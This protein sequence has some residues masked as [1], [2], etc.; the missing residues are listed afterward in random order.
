M[1][2]Y[3]VACFREQGVDVVVVVVDVSV[4]RMKSSDQSAAWAR[5]QVSAIE[6]G[7][8]GT[9]VLLWRATSR[10]L[11]YFDPH[12]R[13]PLLK[14]L[15]PA[16]LARMTN[17]RLTCG[18]HAPQEHAPVATASGM[19]RVRKSEDRSPPPKL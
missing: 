12:H 2:T 10:R 5:M 8:D 11:S 15:T 4:G 13:H 9:V 1:P 17:T 7:L 19:V 3:D 18:E 16:I 6:A 14:H